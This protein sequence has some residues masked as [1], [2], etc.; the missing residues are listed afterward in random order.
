MLG[1]CDCG[2]D[3]DKLLLWQSAKC[4]DDVTADVA[5]DVESEEEPEEEEGFL[6]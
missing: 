5:V 6:V 2:K 1:Q 3:I 4:G